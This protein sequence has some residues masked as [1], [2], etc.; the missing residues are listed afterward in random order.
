MEQVS[1][2][3]IHLRTNKESALASHQIYLN[4]SPSFQRSY[5]SWDDIMRTRFTES[6]I[7]NRAT[8]PIWTVLNEIDESE[9]ILDGMHRITTALSFLNNEFAINGAYLL[10]LEAK[11]YNKLKFK[12]L[13][14]DIQAKVRNYNFTFNKLDSSYRKDLNKLRDMYEILNRSS[15]TLNDYEFNKV[16][17]GP[18]YNIISEHKE[19]FISLFLNRVKDSRGNVDNEIIEILALSDV[20]PKC[21]SSVNNIKDEWI[22]VNLGDSFESVSKYLEENVETINNKLIFICKILVEFS[23]HKLFSSDNKLVRRFFICYKF[24]ISRCGHLI[25]NIATFNRVCPAIIAA[26]NREVL[27]DDIEAKLGCTSRNATFQKRLINKIDDILQQELNVE[28]SSR[29]F[30][31][32]MID[33]KLKEQGNS[34]PL[35]KLAISAE[36]KYEGDHIVPWTAGGKTVPD[37]LQVVHRRCHQLK[38]V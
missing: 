12:D 21:W 22:L 7:L 18:F 8:N 11:D 9:E 28:G 38:S 13:G 29:R 10:T 4:K 24:I 30:S 14:M 23:Q 33:D 36:D 15:R 31:K 37:N 17:L 35:C 27:V 1:L 20:L 2:S 16:I 19:R 26:F 32:K 25:P 34:C 6:I 3:I 5:E